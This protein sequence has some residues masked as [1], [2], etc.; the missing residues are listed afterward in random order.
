MRIGA[1]LLYIAPLTPRIFILGTLSGVISDIIFLAEF[2]GVICNY[3]KD[4]FFDLVVRLMGGK[5][6]TLLLF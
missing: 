4:R 1:G 5:V 6:T 3:T 2:P